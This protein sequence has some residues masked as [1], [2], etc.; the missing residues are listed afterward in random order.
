MCVCVCVCVCVL[1]GNLYLK[2]PG[3]KNSR[4]RQAITPLNRKV[5]FLFM[6]FVCEFALSHVY[7]FTDVDGV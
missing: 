5:R 3:S 6:E 4:Y 1:L 2:G 7:V